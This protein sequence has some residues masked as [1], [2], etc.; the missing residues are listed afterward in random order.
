MQDNVF[1]RGGLKDGLIQRPEV[2]RASELLWT[3]LLPRLR[4]IVQVLQTDIV[5]KATDN[6]ET[7]CFS[8]G[9]EGLLG[10]EGIRNKAIGQLK[11]VIL[12]RVYGPQVNANYG[13]MVVHMLEVVR[14]GT[15]YFFSKSLLG[16]EVNSRP[17]IGINK[18]EAH[19]FEAPLHSRSTSRPEVSYA[20]SL[21][22]GLA[23]IARVYGY[24]P[25]I[26]V[27]FLDQGPVERYP[28]KL[29]P[30]VHTE[31]LFGRAS[32]PPHL[33]EVDAIWYGQKKFHG[34]DEERLKRFA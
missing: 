22:S 13:I 8:S 18:S 28:V 26:G 2:N 10:K 20:W 19:K 11:K 3:P 12:E 9:N 24:C 16:H 6:I 14:N 21:L 5:P 33:K 7:Q 32:E 4:A 27:A 29:L 23:D 25:T 15:S 34:F 17:C 30:E 31:P 1:Q